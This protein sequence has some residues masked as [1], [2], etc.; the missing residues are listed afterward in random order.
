VEAK[1]T[2]VQTVGKFVRT[3]FGEEAH[4]QWVAA[5]PPEARAIHGQPVMSSVWY[6]LGPGLI[7]ATEC[8]CRLFFGGDPQGAWECGRF[9]AED[10]LKGVYKIFLVVGTPGFLI[11]KASSLLPQL[12]RPS[13]IGV[14]GQ[15]SKSVTLHI[16]EFPEPHAILD[17]RI[18]GWMERALEIS[19]CTGVEVNIPRSL[20][21]GDSLT[22]FVIRWS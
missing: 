5:L 22:E 3:R 17:S 4:R 10:G 11:K 12:Y 16:T 21:R 19:A 2:S 14:V 9:S 13:T 15:D 1:G 18:G 20:A 7:D 6:P 8:A